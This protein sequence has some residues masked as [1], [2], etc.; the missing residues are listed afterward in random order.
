MEHSNG[1]MRTFVW[2]RAPSPSAPKD[3]YGSPVSR[4]KLPSSEPKLMR[5]M[6]VS[7]DGVKAR[8]V[9]E[10]CSEYKS[11]RWHAE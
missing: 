2:V 6:T 3:T 5:T 4:S 1:H 9:V 7:L 8:T 10:Y 11:F